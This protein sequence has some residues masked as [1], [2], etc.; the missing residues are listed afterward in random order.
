MAAGFKRGGA[1]SAAA[2]PSTVVKPEGSPVSKLVNSVGQEDKLLSLLKEDKIDDVILP[3]S[4]SMSLLEVA[5]WVPMP[6][7]ISKVM[8]CPGIPIGLVTMV[9][10]KK[11]SGKTTYATEALRSVQEEGG[12]AVLL[13][14]ENKFN[15]KRA[16]MMGVDVKRLLIIKGE[17]IEDI[18]EKFIGFLKRL[19]SDDRYKL[20]RSKKILF[21]WDSLGATPS[22]AEM[23]DKTT[24]FSMTAAKVIKGYMRK[25]ITR[26]R[27]ANAAFLIINQVYANMNTFGKKTTAYG[28]SGPEYHSAVILECTK[29]SRI[30][31]KG[32]KKDAEFA[33]TE[34]EIECT[35]N[36]IGQP[37][38][39]VDVQ[40]DHKGFVIGREVE[41]APEPV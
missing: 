5:G 27:K 39:K 20:F 8:A 11:D 22:K 24:D 17:T 1:Q 19:E 40:I 32:A 3:D 21:V 29:K 16:A 12:I 35:K 9:Q 37:F 33:G 38:R 26:L 30:R 14:T 31:P 36:H 2:P 10:G 15:L 34:V 13:D 7:P 25:L 18:F 4:D 41:Y 6:E 28:G 23:D